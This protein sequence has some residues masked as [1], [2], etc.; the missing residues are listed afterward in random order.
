MNSRR[1]FIGKIAG[2]SALLSSTTSV[3]AGVD[4]LTQPVLPGL[5]G[6]KILFTYGV[7]SFCSE[8]WFSA[9]TVKNLFDDQ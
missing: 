8:F 5:E 4:L 3:K 1:K 9:T 2:A 7:N 6:R